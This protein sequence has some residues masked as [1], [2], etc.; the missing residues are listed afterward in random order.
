MPNWHDM[1]SNERLWTVDPCLT[2]SVDGL[3]FTGTAPAGSGYGLTGWEGWLNGADGRGGPAD[4]TTADGG[5]EG[6]VDM[7]GR[8]ITLE[9]NIVARDRKELWELADR[10][11]R[12][13]A[14]NRWQPM[15]VTEQALALSRQIRVCRLRRPQITFTSWTTA[16]FTL[17]LQAADWRKLDDTLSTVTIKPGETVHAVNAGDLPADLSGVFVG[18]LTR[19]TVSVNGGSWLLD[20]TVKAG[21]TI[22]VDFVRRIVRDPANAARYMDKAWGGWRQLNPGDNTVSLSAVGTGRVD[23]SWR[24]TWS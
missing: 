20:M 2:V 9:G 16:I 12:V 6:R 15:T 22:A 1:V 11:G 14:V 24:S 5:I 13:L 7:D 4:Y 17:E 18:P 19:P 21:Q 23:L 10:L 3:T 8:T